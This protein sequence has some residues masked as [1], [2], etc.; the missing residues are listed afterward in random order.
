MRLQRDL[1]G[2]ASYPLTRKAYANELD[3]ALR[4]YHSL[5]NGAMIALEVLNADRAVGEQL[6]L[7]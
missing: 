1:T 4:Q 6:A 2:A 7:L 3:V 5:S